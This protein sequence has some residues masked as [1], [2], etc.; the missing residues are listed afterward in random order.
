MKNT[1]YLILLLLPF[2]GASQIREKG[3]IELMPIVGHSTSYHIHSLFLGSSYVSGVQL[4][5]YGD[6]YLNDRWSFRSGLLYQSMGT[7]KIYFAIFKNNYSEKTNYITLPLTMNIHFGSTRKWYVNYG[8][9]VGA[10]ISAKADYYDGNGYVD[11]K[12]DANSFQF[13][14]NGGIG[15]KIEVSPKFSIAIDNS[16]MLGLTKTTKE[17]NGRNFYASFNLGAVF[18]IE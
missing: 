15:Y 17:K 14:L 7:E 11:I 6:Y 13:G 12:K 4:G 9:S 1:F 2:M 8:V 5:V 10:L 16:N 3:T 18:K